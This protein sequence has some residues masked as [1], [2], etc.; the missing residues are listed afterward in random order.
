MLYLKFL[1]RFHGRILMEFKCSDDGIFLWISLQLRRRTQRRLWRINFG[2]HY[3]WSFWLQA[4][5]HLC[6][7]AVLLV[8]EFPS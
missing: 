3:D 6:E 8:N 5:A 1:R 7:D 2:L 4:F